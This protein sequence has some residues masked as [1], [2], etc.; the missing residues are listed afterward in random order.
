LPVL[1]LIS[2][3]AFEYDVE[4]HLIII[5]PSIS[6]HLTITHIIPNILAEIVVSVI[7][8]SACDNL[9][10][11]YHGQNIRHDPEIAHHPP[12]SPLFSPTKPVIIKNTHTNNI[13]SVKTFVARGYLNIISNVLSL[14]ALE[15]ALGEY[16]K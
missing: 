4:P 15:R 1:N 3:P 13:L 11:I 2:S 5:I 12:A 6:L 7:I 9:T 8:I 14:T 16:F 10:N